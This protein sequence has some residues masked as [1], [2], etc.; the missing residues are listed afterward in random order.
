M[1]NEI[2]Q[3]KTGRKKRGRKR[4]VLITYVFFGLFVLLLARLLYFTGIESEDFINS[5]YN[6]R[7]SKLSETVERGNIKTS[8]GTVVAET[9]KNDNGTEERNYPFGPM[10]AHSVGYA[11]NGSLGAEKDFNFQMMRSHIFFVKRIYLELSGQKLPGDNLVLTLDS[12][13]QKKAY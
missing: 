2:D 9:V 12:R 8:D 3:E 10:Y 13:L 6:P 1:D 5:S 11:V 4:Y 7:L